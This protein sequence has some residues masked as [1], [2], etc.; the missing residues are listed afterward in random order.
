M[1]LKV[2][3]LLQAVHIREYDAHTA[4]AVTGRLTEFGNPGIHGV[5]VQH[6]GQKIRSVQ[7]F[8]LINKLI[9]CDLGRDKEAGQFQGLADMFGG[10]GVKVDGHDIAEKTPVRVQRVEHQALHA[11]SLQR[12]IPAG[13]LFPDERHV[14]PVADDEA[15]AAGH[16]VLPGF[17][18]PVKIVLFQF[19]RLKHQRRS[20]IFGLAQG[21]AC[22][23]VFIH[24]KHTAVI[25][26]ADAA[27]ILDHLLHDF[28]KGFILAQLDAGADHLPGSFL[29]DALL[30]QVIVVLW[31]KHLGKGAVA[32][33]FI[34]A[35]HGHHEDNDVEGI[36]AGAHHIVDRLLQDGAAV[37]DV[38][39][40]QVLRDVAGVLAVRDKLRL[41]VAVHLH[42][43]GG[44]GQR[45]D[46]FFIPGYDPDRPVPAVRLL[47]NGQHTGHRFKTIRKALPIHP[48]FLA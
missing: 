1:A 38:F 4:R 26:P 47:L 22:A 16:G 40:V 37:T 18:N 33:V 13:I 46:I 11:R 15:E 29:G 43:A 28:G 35:L 45:V 30:R 19:L 32:E 48:A 39:E 42:T 7:H 10:L 9:V 25:R 12:L 21:G 36:A 31:K 34:V 24:Q 14:I 27:D 17:H 5:A 8:Q 2:V 23:P 44:K 41:L 6:A 3:D 20:G